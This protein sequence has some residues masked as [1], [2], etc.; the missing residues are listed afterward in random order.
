[1]RGT[2]VPPPERAENPVAPT[3][4]RA[5]VIC[6]APVGSVTSGRLV[7][8]SGASDVTIRA[9]LSL[10]HLYRARFERPMPIV[11]VWGGS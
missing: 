9:D 3:L 7:F 4:D 6:S 11:R 1:M 2:T 8:A 5:G 10:P